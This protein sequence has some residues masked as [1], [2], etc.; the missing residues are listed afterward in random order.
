MKSKAILVLLLISFI[1]VSCKKTKHENPIPQS[2]TEEIAVKF[3]TTGVP[4]YK[5]EYWN[6][7]KGMNT[8]QARHNC[9]AYACNV[10]YADKETFVATPGKK[11]GIEL[12]DPFSAQDAIKGA[13]ADGLMK[14]N[15]NE[16]PPKGWTKVAL[17]LELE[18]GNTDGTKATDFH[19][20]RR[21]NNGYWS[22]KGGESPVTNEDSMGNKIKDPRSP[23]PDKKHPY[24]VT[25]MAVKSSSKQGQGVTRVK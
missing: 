12:P 1:A 15:G 9:Y 14:L 17:F 13:V 11:A 6:D 8:I 24:F 5:P 20:Y 19:W 7:G 23:D 21:D 22:S 3:D 10:F 16:E 4:A 18:E 25:F 2:S